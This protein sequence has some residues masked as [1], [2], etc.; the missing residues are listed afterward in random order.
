MGLGETIGYSTRLTQNNA[1]GDYSPTAW[2]VGST[3]VA[4]MG[5]PTLRLYPIAPPSDLSAR[6]GQVCINVTHGLP[7]CS[8][9]PNEAVLYWVPSPDP[10]VIGYNLYKTDA[11]H[12]SWTRVNAQPVQGTSYTDNTSTSKYLG[13]TNYMLR[14]VKLQTSPSGSYYDQSEGIFATTYNCGLPASLWGCGPGPM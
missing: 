4:L 8:Q 3:H 14:A 13:D 5:D 6:P 9:V 12:V 1:S 2:Y 10:A 7:I 11:L